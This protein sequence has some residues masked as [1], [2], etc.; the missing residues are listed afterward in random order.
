M[1]AHQEVFCLHAT[2]F[3]FTGEKKP[4]LGKSSRHFLSIPAELS[5][6]GQLSFAT[7]FPVQATSI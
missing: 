2:F 6:A 7:P 3:L 5:S 1:E 4:S